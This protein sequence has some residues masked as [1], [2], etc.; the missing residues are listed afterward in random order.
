MPSAPSR[1]FSA[2]GSTLA[3][4]TIRSCRGASTIQ[5]LYST[6]VSSRCRARVTATPKARPPWPTA[7]ARA[8]DAHSETPRLFTGPTEH[9]ETIPL[10]IEPFTSRTPNNGLQR[11]LRAPRFA[12]ALVPLKPNR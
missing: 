4:V 7:P 9:P 3:F 8:F 12:R 10:T 2:P 1:R 6:L 11:T 5:G